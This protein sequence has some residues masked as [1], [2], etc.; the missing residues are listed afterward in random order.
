MY[1]GGTSL[2]L[3][4]MKSLSGLEARYDPFT[5]QVRPVAALWV[6]R[7]RVDWAN[8]RTKAELDEF[9]LGENIAKQKLGTA[10]ARSRAAIA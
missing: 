7:T 2:I 5:G 3:L 9:V 4:T 10:A 6:W 8:R 1:G